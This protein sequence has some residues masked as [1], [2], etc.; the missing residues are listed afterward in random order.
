MSLR[1]EKLKRLPPGYLGFQ[2]TFYVGNL[3]GVGH[4]YQQTFIDTYSKVAFAK[5]YT[6]KTVISA[7]DILNDKV[8]PCFEGKELPMLR[9]VTDRS[10][11]YGGKVENHD[12]ELYLAINDNQTSAN[13]WHL[14]A[15][16]Q[17]DFAGVLS[18]CL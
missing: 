13:Q 7:I 4:I 5:L 17:N 3:K 1:V 10:S 16:P 11:E 18:G 15:F 14:R 9:I 12:D 6:M 2:D 8:L